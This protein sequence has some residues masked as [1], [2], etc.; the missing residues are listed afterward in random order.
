MIAMLY[1][2]LMVRLCLWLASKCQLRRIT[3]EDDSPYLDR[4]YL[5]GNEPKYFPEPIKPRLGWLPWTF[6]LHRFRDSDTDEELHNHPWDASASLILAGGYVEERLVTKY[7]PAPSLA[8]SFEA[9]EEPY[10][11]VEKRD[12]GP[13][14]INFIGKDDFHRV[15]LKGEEAWTVFV[16]GKKAQSWGFKHP[17]DGAY[18]PWREHLARRKA[19][20]EGKA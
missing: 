3:R 10:Q 8:L 20:A 14:R 4:Y 15:T 7:R 11:V 12:L 13:L 1:E 6:F 2:K 9:V 17:K 5:F 18:V 16:T 19:K